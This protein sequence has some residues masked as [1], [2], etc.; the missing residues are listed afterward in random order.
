MN[1]AQIISQLQ[2]WLGE[3]GLSFFREVKEKHGRVDACW[4]EGAEGDPDKT[5]LANAID[6]ARF[7]G[8]PHPVHFREGMQVRNF[9]SSLPSCSFS[10]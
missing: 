7:P 3:D 9:L 1:E 4:L 5:A 10:F 2:E 8:I 6:K